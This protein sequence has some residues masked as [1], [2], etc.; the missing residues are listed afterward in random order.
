P[1]ETTAPTRTPEATT[2]TTAPCPPLDGATQDKTETTS[3]SGYGN[4]TEV[5]IT[6]GDCTDAVAFT[7]TATGDGPD[8]T[9]EYQPGPFTM[10]ASGD[11]VDVDGA[12]F[13][14]VRFTPAYGFN[15]DTGQATYNGPDS[16]TSPGAFFVQEVAKTGDFEG[17]VSWV[18]G[19]DQARDYAVDVTGTTTKVITISIR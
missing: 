3:S 14:T 1:E 5:A 13:L 11:P 10:D 8:Y 16:V 6:T 19:V 7:F 12:A 4:L 9:I 2:A 18:I 15:F 17:V